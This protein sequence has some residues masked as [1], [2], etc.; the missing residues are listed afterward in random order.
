M[1]L[2]VS[3]LGIH[4][5]VLVGSVRWEYSRALSNTPCKLRCQQCR[6]GL[7]LFQKN[8]VGH[9]QLWPESLFLQVHLSKTD[10]PWQYLVKTCGKLAAG[11]GW[12]L[13]QL[14][15]LIYVPFFATL[16]GTGITQQAHFA[17]S[18][19][20]ISSTSGGIGNPAR[21][22]SN[23]RET[24]TLHNCGSIRHGSIR[25]RF[26]TVAMRLTSAEP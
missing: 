10:A 18:T 22:I 5:G 24:R 14:S 8:D 4:P 25:T 7:G 19:L 15:T 1:H 17:A 9:A 21:W 26:A 13:T 3:L 20:Q 23:W 12:Y 11:P 16:A 6:V 2:S